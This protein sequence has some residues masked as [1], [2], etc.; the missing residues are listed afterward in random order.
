MNMNSLPF[1]MQENSSRPKFAVQ[2]KGGRMTSLPVDKTQER[3]NTCLPDL[4]FSSDNQANPRM[5]HI[6]KSTS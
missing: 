4:G 1:W 2:K 6:P 3:S 5:V